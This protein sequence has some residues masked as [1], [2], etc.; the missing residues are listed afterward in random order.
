MLKI[1]YNPSSQVE[2]YWRIKG[3]SDVADINK[4]TPGITDQEP[5]NRLN[6]RYHLSYNTNPNLRFR[7]RIEIARYKTGEFSPDWGYILYQDIL[8]TFRQLPIDLR[9]RYAIFDTDSYNTRIYT[10]ENDVL[11][12]FSVPALYSKGTRS[13]LL[14]KYS[15][16]NAL[17]FWLKYSRTRYS[18]KIPD[19]FDSVTP[20]N[21]L[22]EIKFQ[23]RYKF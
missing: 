21:V 3:E 7:N 13:Y 17:S 20:G 1:D 15:P 2:M 4:D 10:Y 16:G 9:A 19:G 12:S 18:N 23:I 6:L 11:Y 5:I 14:V 22:S 8:F